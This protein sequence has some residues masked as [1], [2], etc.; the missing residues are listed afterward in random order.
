MKRTLSLISSL[1]LFAVWILLAGCEENSQKPTGPGLG[2]A[3]EVEVAV[4][5]EKQVTEW[6][7]FTGR[8]AAVSSVEIRA[9]V[10]GYLESVHFREGA[11]VQKGDLLFIIDPRPYE[12]ALKIRNAELM[13]AQAKLKQATASMKR[14][15]ELVGRKAISQ[16][17]YD[18]R[19]G[20]YEEAG[21]AVEVGR[22]GVLIMELDVEYTHV[23]APLTGR[24]GRAQVTAGNLVSGGSTS[25]TLLANLVSMDPIHFYFTGNERDRLRYLRLGQE[26][27]RA[28]SA[29]FANTVHLKIPDEEGYLHRGAMDFVD[30]QIDQASGTITGR[31]VFGNPDHILIPGMFGKI[32]LK[33]EGPFRAFLIPDK[34]IVTAQS[35]QYVFVL[36][37]DDT[38][39]QRVITP[40]IM[41]YGLRAVRTGISTED[42][43]IVN[44]L[45]RVRA[46]IKVN[47]TVV[48]LTA[49][50]G[51]NEMFETV[52]EGV[53][54]E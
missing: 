2:Q 18:Q 21:A 3:P 23:R 39:R 34:A 52:P 15:K 25:S 33:G 17:V 4:P 8:L 51:E 5:L 35:Q 50:P 37:K 12:A 30:N 6:D 29:R 45:T 1:C 10:S 20:E 42:R 22:A 46:G 43:V 7:E 31:A 40:G 13:Q 36:D 27:L 38:V 48:E 24:I 26:G 32:K 28:N 49:R 9:R 54:E 11:M 19:L 44:G 47:P 41:A 16:E 14:S 53:D